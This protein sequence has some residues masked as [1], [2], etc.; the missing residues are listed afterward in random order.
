M[1]AVPWLIAFCWASCI[2]GAIVKALGAVMG[3]GAPKAPTS[4]PPRSAK[5]RQTRASVPLDTPE[6][7][8]A[9]LA[10]CP[11]YDELRARLAVET[12]PHM[13]RYLRD[14]AAEIEEQQYDYGRPLDCSEI[15]NLDTENLF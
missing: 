2:V 14:C 7:K 1:T 9:F 12:R 3:H 5:P 4:C 6:Q 13:K 10:D 15:E 11:S 8:A